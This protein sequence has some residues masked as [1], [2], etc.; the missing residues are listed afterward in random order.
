MY[1]PKNVSFLPKLITESRQG[2][3]L[4]VALKKEYF[5]KRISLRAIEIRVQER[6][7]SV[8]DEFIL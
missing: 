1:N 2:Q 7:T 5:I 6:F 4:I 8:R 3:R